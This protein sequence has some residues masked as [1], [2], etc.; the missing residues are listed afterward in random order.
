MYIH[1]TPDFENIDLFKLMSLGL[2]EAGM[3]IRDLLNDLLTKT[4]KES[5]E[6]ISK[7]LDEAMSS[8]F[9]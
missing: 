9:V 8:L 4:E 7:N 2:E 1:A 5:E 6:S 3:T